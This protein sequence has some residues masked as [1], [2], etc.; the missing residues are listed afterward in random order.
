MIQF[1]AENG[2]NLEAQDMWGQTAMSIAMADPDGFVYRNLPDQSED[3]TF[4]RNLKKDLKTIDLL[5]RLGASPYIP[6]GRDLKGF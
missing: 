5:L 1:L 4:R 3:F 2:A 6:K